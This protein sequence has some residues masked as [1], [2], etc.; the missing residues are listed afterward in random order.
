MR[1]YKDVG[2]R[3][4]GLL[5][6]VC[7]LTGL[8][9]AIP[10]KAEDSY[11]IKLWTDE[12][13]TEMVTDATY[14]Y[15]GSE[16]TPYVE[17]L[18]AA[19]ISIDPSQYTVDYNSTNVNAGTATVEVW[20]SG[21]YDFKLYSSFK[22]NAAY[23]D[24]VRVTFQKD[25]LDGDGVPFCYYTG[26]ATNPVIAKVEGELL[27]TSSYVELTKDKDYT[28]A[29]EN[30]KDA[31]ADIM[32]AG[33]PKYTVSLMGNYQYAPDTNAKSG[34]YRIYYN[35]DNVSISDIANQVYNGG[36]H[37]PSFTVTNNVKPDDAVTYD[38]QWNDNTNA[39]TATLKLVGQGK[40]KGSITKEFQIEQANISTATITFDAAEYDYTGQQISMEDHVK[41]MLGDYEVSTDD[42]TITYRTEGNWGNNILTFFGKNNLTGSANASYKVVNRLSACTLSSLELTYNGNKN[43]PSLTVTD[44][45]GNVVSADNYKV[46][47]YR[48]PAGE[49]ESIYG[50][51]EKLAD[52]E[53]PTEVGTYYIKI[54]GTGFFKETLGDVDKP[55]SFRIV[56]KKIGTAAFALNGTPVDETMALNV[57]FKAGTAQK[58]TLTVTDDEKSLTEGVDYKVEYFTDKEC[59][60]PVT[61]W[62]NAG[63]Y[64]LH[65]TGLSSYEGS[66]YTLTYVIKARR[67]TGLTVTVKPQTYTGS[68]IVPDKADIMVTATG[69]TTPL[70]DYT[71]ACS[72]NINIGTAKITITLGGN[73]EGTVTGTFEIVK[74]YMSD[75]TITL[76]A[77]SAIYNG[78]IQKP[79]ITVS[80]KFKRLVEGTDYEVAYYT[81]TACTPEYLFDGQMNVGTCYVA[82]TG[83]GYYEG[84]E[85]RVFAIKPKPLTS[86][87]I[88][89]SA[90]NHEYTGQPV[91]ANVTVWDKTKVLVQGTDYE[92]AGYY[93][94]EEC[95]VVS[96]RISGQVYVQ[97]KGKGNYSSTDTRVTSFFIGNDINDL[98]D[99]LDVSSELIY[100]RTSQYDR[101][102]AALLVYN[103]AGEV[104]STDKY[105]VHFY[106]DRNHTTEITNPTNA[107]FV[108]AGTIY[109]GIQGRNGYYGSYYGTCAIGRKSIS[110]LDK[111]V[112][113][114]Y[115]YTGSDIRL[116][117]N[118]GTD[119]SKPDGIFLTYPLNDGSGSSYTLNANEYEIKEY[120]DNRNAGTAT[121][122]L[123]GKGNYTGTQTV[124]FTIGR[125]SLNDLQNLAV[126]IPNAIYTSR[127]QLP[128]VTITYGADN[129]SLAGDTDFTLEY[130]TNESY[131]AKASDL[132]L[133]NAG[134]VFVKI[135]GINNYKDVLDS[136]KILGTNQYVIQP[137]DIRETVVSLEGM[138]YVY[139]DILTATKIP[140]FTV[141]FQYATGSYYTLTAGTDYTY[142]P[143]TMGYSIG[144]QILDI[145]AVA[146][147][148][149]T[150]DKEIKYYHRGNMKNEAGEIRVE[151]ITP[152]VPYTAT[153]GQMGAT[154]SNIVV[155]SQATGAEIAKSCYSIEYV[156]NKTVGTATVRIIGKEAQ[157]WTGTYEQTFKITGLISEAEVRIPDQVYTGEAYTADT[158]RNI[159]VTCHGY[160][161]TKDEDY[162]IERVDNA[163]EAALSTAGTTAPSITLVGK[164]DF[165]PNTTNKLNVNF[166]IKYDI[167][168]E[169]LK[170]ADIPAQDYTGSA[171]EPVV[172]VEYEK[173]SGSKAPLT[174][175]VDYTVEY[176]NNTEVSE[177]NGIRGPYAV[178]TATDDGLLLAGSRTVPFAIGMVDI[179]ADVYGFKIVGLEPEYCYTGAAIRPQIRIE[180]I[181]GKVLD[182]KNY[183]VKCESQ[184]WEAGTVVPLSVTG[185]GNYYG[186]L[187]ASFLIVTRSLANDVNQ[188]QAQISDVVYNGAAQ[189]PSFKVTF[190]D[191]NLD[192]DGK[193][194]TQTLR[195]GVD[196]TIVSYFNNKDAGEAGTEYSYE[197]GPYVKIQAVPGRSIVGERVIPFTIKPREM[198]D[199]YYTRVENPVY[200]TGKKVYTPEL[201][202]KIAAA[203]EDVLVENNDYI[204]TYV[205]NTQVAA[206]N[207]VMGPY[208]EVSAASSNFTGTH[209]IPFSILAK[210]ITGEEFEVTLQEIAGGQFNPKKWNY[211]LPGT[212]TPQVTLTD[213]TDPENPIDLIELTDYQLTYTNNNTVGTAT[214][215]ITA[216]GNYTGTRLVKFT[217]GTLFDDS[218]ISV[219]QGNTPVVSGF[220]DV[221]YNGKSQTPQDVMVK[222]IIEPVAELTEGVDYAVRYYTD[223]QC[224]KPI[225]AENVINAGTYYA[226]LEGL[227]TAGY[228]GGIVIPFTIKQK[229]LNS[230]DVTV[231]T[232]EDQKFAG[233]NV[234]PGVILYDSSVVTSDGTPMKIP[235]SAYDVTYQD[236]NSI[237]NAIATVTAN[238]N[239]NYTGTRDIVFK[240]VRQDI[241]EAI[242][243]PI[244]D[245][246]YTGSA[247]LPDPVIYFNSTR[248]IKGKDY[249]L[250]PNP[251]YGDNIQA[252][253][254]WLVIQGIGNYTGAIDKTF[255]IKANLDNA[256][257]SAVE[258]QPYT[259]KEIK[260][261]VTVYCGGNKLTAG[262]EYKI[263]YGQNIAVGDA[264]MLL[265]P[266]EAYK[267]YY[268]G[269]HVVRFTI[270]N[271][272]DNAQISGI[273]SSQTYTG[274]QIMPEPV[275]RIGAV[276]LTKGVDY[277]VRWSNNVNVGQA[278]VTI[279]GTGRYAGSKT[280]SF[281]I[282]AKSITRCSV[283]KITAV[284]YN[285]KAHTPTVVV[286]DGKRILARNVDY[287]ISYSHNTKIGTGIISVT[288]I[289]NYS[290][291]SK[292]KF[293]IVSA[294][295]TGLKFTAASTSS[296]KLSWN[297]KSNITGYE[298]Y[299]SNG[300]TRLARTKK[301]NITLKNLKSGKP[302]KYKVRTYTVIGKKT[303]YGAFKTITVSTKPQAP[304][305]T[306]RSSAKGTVRISWKRVSGATGYEIFAADA[307]NGAYK[308]LAIIVK[309]NTVR[310]T[311]KKQKSGAGRYFRVRAYR[312]VDG[313]K[314]YSS[315]SGVSAVT[316]K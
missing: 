12:N 268:S 316:I 70:T 131:T 208:I 39:G 211:P 276:T 53:Y 126:K 85:K 146:D 198:D 56:P 215:T 235:A 164:G 218:N 168:S 89:L 162:T 37:T 25:N 104:I 282:I 149:F 245:Y 171:I 102:L 65:I 66:E 179:T 17:V 281:K 267:D 55:I 84:M 2:K 7:M 306:V 107:L 192:A 259:G 195:E 254:A 153:V 24:V 175:D 45:I 180:D 76:S 61:S 68:A 252:G 243:Y 120:R 231:E 40:Y 315:Y 109:V 287:T 100:D 41:V 137:R 81:N 105:T 207:G 312:A 292:I 185:K 279:T 174:R 216:R 249:R 88:T 158:L 258:S 225:L 263:T 78:T 99:H 150:G 233:G 212:Y 251:N 122:I 219:T 172:T 187:A 236:N 23:I 285:K 20:G 29:Y 15:T 80:D 314:V 202:V 273:P 148:N 220:A 58:P 91:D 27:N 196:Y 178:V 189:T 75:C 241:S 260:P 244:P 304:T 232:I 271:T 34:S 238:E 72:N 14:S 57:S 297:K 229:N 10:A 300:R 121:V 77:D 186:T 206:A 302:Y 46:T 226:K 234:K 147:G 52:S 13:K 54:E 223:A 280:V 48:E 135:T 94:N 290:G 38:T 214:I 115:T 144:E 199:L 310:Y 42:Y 97:I 173:A 239:G 140:E 286:R 156:N 299:T 11:T 188:V 1:R 272:V 167:N 269:S 133:T 59:T 67:L 311:N 95:T 49:N 182:P 210:D 228:I 248:L 204:L 160:T 22:I 4:L 90:A 237:G 125:R 274:D 112:G 5:L 113:G 143:D 159:Q 301:K 18:D 305:I 43:V 82:I 118:D 242:I 26:A 295:I 293:A 83:I 152:T 166:S 69:I 213:R 60:V 86:T 87:D 161:L 130:Y 194:R 294:P 64:Y 35:M 16:I 217:I 190:E 32:S 165:F 128:S 284:S 157:Y 209:L 117:I 19:G 309:G 96:S 136:T 256:V 154:F 47:Y 9:P 21:N 197:T 250:M 73:Y 33:R 296:V 36:R 142:S 127:K 176:F 203:S 255:R 110:E 163:T 261:T 191:Y 288:G 134:T 222:R 262:K 205:N 169:N 246:D 92:I 123:A 265:E 139:S 266:T 28:I 313:K 132:N 298:V 31:C 277:T 6:T 201:S 278:S 181:N 101:I 111:K 170:I 257:V 63:S 51:A 129:V 193:G 8:L 247:I 108:N 116:V 307:A 141:R 151:G 50:E 98:T 291:I 93:E 270:C 184:S 227:Q 275:V 44:N 283:N 79:A 221:V 303:Y 253:Q 124:V 30:N 106:S 183:T 177:A 230:A 103:K 74:R 114:T 71:I 289:G 155:Y 119:S 200:E 264:Y 308:K 240:I 145:K 3:I 224:E 62:I 138:T